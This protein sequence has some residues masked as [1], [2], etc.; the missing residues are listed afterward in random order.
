MTELG[1]HILVLLGDPTVIIRELP[2]ATPVAGIGLLVAL[3]A[4]VYAFA[5]IHTEN[6]K[7]GITCACV[8]LCVLFLCVKWEE[9]NLSQKYHMK[10]APLCRGGHFATIPDKLSRSPA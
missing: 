8:C 5:R 4:R 1:L 3:R 10:P 7:Y 9:Y 2:V 6:S